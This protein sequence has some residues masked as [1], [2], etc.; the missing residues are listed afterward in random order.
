MILR[1]GL[2][3]AV[4]ALVLGASAASAEPTTPLARTLSV[5]SRDDPH[6]GQPFVG[7]VLVLPTAARRDLVSVRAR[8]HGTILRQR[9]RA[10]ATRVPEQRAV[11]S[12]LLCTW[13]IPRDKVGW[14]FR[15]RMEVEVQRRMPDGSIELHTDEGRTTAWIVQP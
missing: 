4:V 5:A 12:V 9:V 10:Q 7:Y 15:A 6:A 13:S 11:P 2:A 1:L 14:T 8:C 3:L